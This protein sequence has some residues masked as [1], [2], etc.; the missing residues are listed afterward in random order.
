[1]T[2]P[3]LPVGEVLPTLRATLATSMSAVL[4]A[5]PG[6]GKTTLVPLALLAAPWL[7]GKS[8]IVLEPR[9]VAARAAAARM[10]Q[11][12]AEAVGE[13]VGYQVR[14]DRKVGPR[15]RVEV[16]T[17]GLLTRR[18]QADA[19]LPGVGL[20]IFDEFH[21]RSLEADLALAL[22]VDARANLRPDLRVLVMS[23]TLNAERI[24]A[25][26]DDAPVVRSDG[27]MFPVEVVYRPTTAR[28][29]EAVAGAVMAG[30]AEDEGDVLAFLPGAREIR[31]A[32][33]LIESRTASR[34]AAVRV[35]P[36]YGALEAS[37]QDAALRP[38][39]DGARKVILATNIAQTSLTV[40]G[41][42]TVVDGGWVRVAAYDLASGAN[43]LV[44][45]RISRAAAE[46]RAGRAGRLGPGRVIRL[47]SQDQHG[48]LAAFDA[49]EIQQ[50]D[51]SRFALELAV[52]G[53]RPGDAALL[54]APP[55]PAWSVA[56]GLLRGIAAV[57]DQG[58]ATPLGQALLNVPAAPRQAALLHRAQRQGLGELAVWLVAVLDEG[59]VGHDLG[60]AV[61][62][63]MQGRAPA[64]A[65]RR[66]RDTVRQ[67]AQRLKVTPATQ[68]DERDLARLVAFAYPERLAQRRGDT[69]GVF[70]CADG[71][72]LRVHGASPL[73]QSPWLAVAHW[74]PGPPRTLRSGLVMDEATLR[75][76]FADQLVVD[77]AVGWDARAEAVRTDTQTRLGA[78]IIDQRPGRPAADRIVDGVLDGL[79]QLGLEVLPWT[80]ALRQWQA[81]VQCLRQWQPEAG[82]PDVGDDAL[83]VTRAHWLR[84]F[85]AGVSR[86]SHFDRIPLADALQGLLDYPAQQALQRLAPTHL[87]VPSGHAH[88]LHYAEGALPL[89]EVKL[90]EMFGAQETPTVC[91][92][93]VPVVLHLLS[94]ARRPVAVT[95]DIKGFWQG[96]YI[97]VRKDL[98]GRYPRH[99]WPVDPTVAS[100]TARAKPRGT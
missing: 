52:W 35:Y 42:T 74:D 16:L 36:L 96:G 76:D 78:L 91:N 100:A 71:R 50:V 82:W 69:V 7:A 19:E 56:Q 73:A 17:E 6:S 80:P 11:L 88:R 62:R 25:L 10:A 41:V 12:C 86:R 34:A 77:D 18:L 46:Q 39:P 84:P 44:T 29:A 27:R 60:E 15:T 49:P 28:V 33:Q 90:Q 85:L 66:V 87:T 31:D 57:D 5:P 64:P 21:E 13:T 40:E 1:M 26:L 4:C 45:R 43:R 14:F 99:P 30:L 53:L 93:R 48:G 75:A 54:D 98:R 92:G 65:Q 79:G 3:D 58:R 24:A 8:I 83:L 67:L 22:T 63:F 59:E 47:W 70:L 89:L 51:L 97:D 20:V 61:R 2:L 32:Q 38:D 68:A 55:A 9:R 95:Q 81:R 37:A 94:P 72:E 23:A